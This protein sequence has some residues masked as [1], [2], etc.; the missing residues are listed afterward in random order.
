MDRASR[1]KADIEKKKEENIKK[2]IQKGVKKAKSEARRSNDEEKI[3][4]R[5]QLFDRLM[6]V[7][8]AKMMYKTLHLLL[9]VSQPSNFDVGMVKINGEGLIK[10]SNL[11]HTSTVQS[12]P[13]MPF[14]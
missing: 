3:H 11:L 10:V 7:Q 12:K 13:V 8:D 14:P 1:M 6:T 9:S 5:N 2:Q 4:R